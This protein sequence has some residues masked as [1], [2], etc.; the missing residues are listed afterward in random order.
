MDGLPV[1]IRLIDPPLHEFLPD[2]TDLSVEVA[3]ADERGEARRGRRRDELL[4]AVRRLHEQNPMLGLRG[5]R[6]GHRD[7]RPVRDAGPGD[8][9]RRRPSASPAGGRPAPEIMIPLVG[10]VQELRR[11]AA[12]PSTR[13]SPRSR[14][15]RRRA[16]AT[17]G[18]MIELPRAALTAGRDRGVRASSSPSAPTT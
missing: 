8:R 5:V 6:L 15:R 3:L 9:S 18:T 1:T 7:P 4:E 17:V 14:A 13:C 12:R 11:R 2:F 16:H 10:A